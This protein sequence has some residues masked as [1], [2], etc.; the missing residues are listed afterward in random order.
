MALKVSRET[1]ESKAAWEFRVCL[2]FLEASV[3]M[4]RMVML[5]P[6]VRTVL[7][8]F[9]VLVASLVV[10]ESVAPQVLLAQLAPSGFAASLV[11]KAQLVPLDRQVLVET[12]AHKVPVVIL[13]L[14]D[15]VGLPVCQVRTAGTVS[16]A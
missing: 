6:L 7:S 15:P 5:V 1:K 10:V 12:L 4:A 13:G 3:Q 16:M 8:D 9:V 14:S 11:R 2:E